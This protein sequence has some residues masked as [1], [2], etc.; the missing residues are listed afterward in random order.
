MESLN[1]F[2]K[3]DLR[4]LK[5]RLVLLAIALI[6]AVSLYFS[7]LIYRNEIRR[8]EVGVRTNTEVLQIQLREI[9]ESERIIIDNIDFYND[10]VADGIMSEENRVLLLEDISRIRERHGFFPI[11]VEI[12]EQE[13]QLLAYDV[14]VEAPD[15]LISLRSSQVFIN[16]PLLHERDLEVFLADFLDTGRLMVANSCNVSNTLADED[17]ILELVEHQRAL[18]EFSWFTL[19]REPLVIEEY[20]E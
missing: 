11:D 6:I 8:Q 20:L 9:E 16:M 17:E 3:E 14:S 4:W 15:E 5:W 18:C 13:R 10:M 1:R 12:A 2:I 7:V 19:R